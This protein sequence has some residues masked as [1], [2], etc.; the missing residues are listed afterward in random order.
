MKRVTNKLLLIIALGF[1]VWELGLGDIIIQA[2]PQV[3]SGTW[4]PITRGMKTATGVTFG[5]LFD[6]GL[7]ADNNR[8]ASYREAAEADSDG[9]G[10]TNGEEY[11]A[12]TH[13]TQ[14]N[15]FFA[16]EQTADTLRWHSATGRTYTLKGA[17]RLTE[18]FSVIS[19]YTGVAGTLTYSN[20]YSDGFGFYRLE[21]RLSD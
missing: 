15:S 11:I 7:V 6:H 4:V 2:T 14:S 5:W 19:N 13:P 21:A 1:F 16:I 3:I 10:F 17:A 12:D 8:S 18:G 9:D 20:V